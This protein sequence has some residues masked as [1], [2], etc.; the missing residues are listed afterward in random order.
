MVFAQS[1]TLL[2]VIKRVV[3]QFTTEIPQPTVRSEKNLA[4]IEKGAPGQELYCTQAII[5]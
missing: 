4:R 1:V 3:L 2:Q 5:V